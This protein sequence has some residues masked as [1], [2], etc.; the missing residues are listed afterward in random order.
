MRCHCGIIRDMDEQAILEKLR[1]DRGCYPAVAA[2][3]GIKYTT[4]T[5]IACG[6]TKRPYGRTMQALEM[7]YS[8]QGSSRDGC[9]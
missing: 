8:K 4:L 5:K 3:T 2:A 1:Q 6:K 9:Q 7:Y